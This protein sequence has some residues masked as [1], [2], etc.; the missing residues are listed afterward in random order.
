MKTLH[1]TD[2]A[3]ADRPF[4]CSRA[5]SDG[6]VTL[7]Y[8]GDEIPPMPE[9]TAAPSRY[10]TSAEYRARFTQAELLAMLSSTDAG[11]KLLILKVSTAPTEGINLYSQSVVDGL[12]YLVSKNILTPE[13]VL[14]ILA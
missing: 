9:P 4:E 1:P 3:D 2:I 5:N 12:T 7:Y 6:T 13:R 10:I 11:V 8:T 14:E